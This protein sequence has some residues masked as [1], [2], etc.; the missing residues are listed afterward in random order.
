MTLNIKIER[1]DFVKPTEVRESIVQS[2]VDYFMR[3]K[4]NEKD[5]FYKTFYIFDRDVVYIDGSYIDCPR[6]R[7]VSRTTKAGINGTRVHSVEMEAAFDVMKKAGYLF[8]AWYCI[9]DKKHGFMFSKYPMNGWQETPDAN[10]GL[11][12]D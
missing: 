5:P 12:I 3:Y 7:A 1:N 8:Y 11:C 10:F 4:I 6:L 9:T 2:I